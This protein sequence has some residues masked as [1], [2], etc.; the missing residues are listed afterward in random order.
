MRARDSSTSNL[1][2]SI[3]KKGR[4]MSIYETSGV[5]TGLDLQVRSTIG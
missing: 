4:E 1:K 3:G 2:D 5:V